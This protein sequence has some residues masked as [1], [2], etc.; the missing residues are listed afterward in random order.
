MLTHLLFLSMLWLAIA[1]LLVLPFGTRLRIANRALSFV[2][3]AALIAVGDVVA[4]GW[5]ATQDEVV[6]GSI[7]ALI[8]GLFLVLRLPDWNGLG[9]AFFLFCCTSTVLYLIYAFAV[10]AF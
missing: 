1:F 10:T 3:V 6:V 9:H 8:V 4:L 2:M 7:V 5:F